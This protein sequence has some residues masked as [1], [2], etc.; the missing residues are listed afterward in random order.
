MLAR[1]AASAG[2]L[3]ARAAAAAR[4]HARMVAAGSGGVGGG[5][6]VSEL[7]G[8]GGSGGGGG[9]L[10]QWERDAERARARG[11]AP[12]PPPGVLRAANALSRRLARTST[13]T[14]LEGVLR[15]VTDESASAG[16]SARRAPLEWTSEA[17][18]RVLLRARAWQAAHMLGMDEPPWEAAGV[19]PQS[20]HFAAAASKLRGAG[21]GAN[22]TEGLLATMAGAGVVPCEAMATAVLRRAHGRAG[23]VR[24]L[25]ALRAAGAEAGGALAHAAP[26]AAA[27]EAL[28]AHGDLDGALDAVERGAVVFGARPDARS[29]TALLGG[30]DA[31]GDVSRV[32]ASMEA[33]G[34]RSAECDAVFF[35]ALLSARGREAR[36]DLGQVSDGGGEQQERLREAVESVLHEMREAGVRPDEATYNTLIAQRAACGDRAGAARVLAEMVGEAGLAPGV[37]TFNALLSLL[38]RVRGAGEEARPPTRGEAAADATEAARLIDA[39]NAAGVAPNAMTFRR[40]LQACGAARRWS[41]AVALL[42]EMAERRLRPSAQDYGDLLEV[43]LARARALAW[44]VR[45]YRLAVG[46][47]SW[48]AAHSADN[49][50]LCASSPAALLPSTRACAC[51][52]QALENAPIIESD[53]V[54]REDGTAGDGDG[55]EDS[56]DCPARREAYADELLERLRADGHDVVGGKVVDRRARGAAGKAAAR[57]K[58]RRRKPMRVRR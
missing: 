50:S 54:A 17:L 7:G 52:H 35:N 38:S 22:P 42:D 32:R 26:H 37:R 45:A 12:P 34:V 31:P 46:T 49:G 14:Q 16:V 56:E 44:L 24:A 36:G 29:F 5:G 23:V 27:A 28:C 4:V 10:S 8:V 20:A 39:M 6:D 57:G 2:A 53:V 30:C 11:R 9:E 13:P 1:T 15:D 41:D 18:L 55:E 33:N 19:S 51:V 48:C 58:P 47:R 3:A 40:L 21:D 43:R 25:D